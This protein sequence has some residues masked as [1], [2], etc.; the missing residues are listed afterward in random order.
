MALID[1]LAAAR[2][3]WS[4]NAYVNSTVDTRNT[5]EVQIF[6]LIQDVQDTPPIFSLAPPVTTIPD[7]LQPVN[8]SD[9]FFMTFFPQ[10][11]MFC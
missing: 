6:V 7:T 10:F 4:Q 3:W 2:R 5:V 11:P 8:T 1:W 9:S